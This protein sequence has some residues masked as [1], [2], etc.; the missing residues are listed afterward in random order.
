M[1]ED[2]EDRLQRHEEMIQ[3]LAK[4]WIPLSGSVPVLRRL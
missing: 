1:P 2:F 3:A 4:V